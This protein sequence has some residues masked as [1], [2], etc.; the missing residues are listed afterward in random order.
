MGED[1]RILIIEDSDLDAKLIKNK[2]ADGGVV[3]KTKNADCRAEL[4]KVIKGYS[5]DLVICD[6]NLKDLCAPEIL[7]ILKK[8]YPNTPVI[9]VS[10]TFGEKVVV[11]TIKLGATDYIMK[12]R[13][14]RLVPSVKRALE[15][16]RIHR[17]LD[18]TQK[19]LL[20]IKE[21]QYRALIDNIPGKI[22]LKNK[23]S[24]Y[25]S[26]NSSY[27]EDLKISPEEIAGKTD[28]DFFP[29][30]LAEKY[31][32]DDKRIMESGKTETTEEEYIVITDFLRE[33]KSAFVSTIKVPVI[34]EAGKVNGIF[35]IFW[36]ITERKKAENELQIYHENLEKM[37]REKTKAILE[38]ESRFK[39]IFEDARDGILLAD[40]KTKKFGMCNK[41]ICDMLGYTEKEMMSLG[42]DDIHPEDS[43]PEVVKTFEKQAKGLIKLGVLPVKRKNDSVFY[44][45]VTASPISLSGKEYLMGN[46][47]D[48]TERKMTEEAMV[49]A[50]KAKS[51]FTDMVSHELRTPLTAIKEGISV[52]LDKVTGEPGEEQMKYLNIAKNNVDRLSRLITAVLDFQKLESGKMEF[53]MEEGDLHELIDDIY[54]TMMPLFQKKGL[55]FYCKLCDGIPKLNF[56]KDKIVQV[57][58]NLVNNAFKFTDKGSVTISTSKGDNFVQVMVKDTGIGIKEDSIKKL[59]Q[60]FTQLERKVGGSGLGLS[61][62]KKIIDAHKGKIWAESKFGDGSTFYFTLPIKERRA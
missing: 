37:V 25:I 51:D 32:A 31:R 59:F 9:I 47:R 57:L 3:C 41:A 62:S 13:M 18:K 10:G 42:I 61:I 20:N 38:S 50:V 12:D 5:P 54:R 1:L 11:D 48:I 49:A 6:Y 55:V 24:V 44:A 2:L 33:A 34:D 27:A 7:K 30:H 35:G 16:T 43:L 8:R 45:E 46:F 36:D 28:F 4:L 21:I 29:T 58:T 19:E 53:I 17:E 39:T 14:E 22:F 56:D 52:V 40:I 15:E 23:D 60:Q 26:C